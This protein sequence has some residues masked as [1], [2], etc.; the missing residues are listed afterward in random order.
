[1]IIHGT[2]CG[3]PIRELLFDTPDRFAI[4]VEVQNDQIEEGKKAYRE[5]FVRLVDECP[6]LAYWWMGQDVPTARRCSPDPIT[7]VRRNYSVPTQAEFETVLDLLPLGH[8]GIL[9]LPRS[10]MSIDHFPGVGDAP[11]DADPDPLAP[12]LSITVFDRF[13]AE[14]TDLK[15]ETLSWSVGAEREAME[16]PGGWDIERYV[17]VL[18][19]KNQ[20]KVR[21]LLESRVNSHKD[22]VNKLKDRYSRCAVVF[23]KV[24]ASNLKSIQKEL[25]DFDFHA[26]YNK[27]VTIYISKGIANTE[28]F[29]NKAKN[30][31]LL[32]G[33]S[34]TDHWNCLSEALKRW[35]TVLAYLQDLKNH[36]AIRGES[37]YIPVCDPLEAEANSGFLRDQEIIDLGYTVYISEA[38]RYRMLNNSLS[39][40]T[41]RF[42]CVMDAMSALD[43]RKRFVKNYLNRLKIREDD[44]AGQ[45]D[46]TNE[47]NKIVKDES[48]SNRRAMNAVK[49]KQNN[50][51]DSYKKSTGKFPAGSCRWHP[52]ATTHNTES[53][54]AKGEASGNSNN[55][56][57]SKR[58]FKPC[59][60]CKEHHPHLADGHPREKC[61]SDENSP[62]FKGV[63][64]AKIA[65][66]DDERKGNKKSKKRKAQGQL[67]RDDF[68]TSSGYDFYTSNQSQMN[69]F[70]KR[71]SVN[72]DENSGNDE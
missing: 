5:S 68:K 11:P 45:E 59:S 3:K 46:I 34:I 9:G 37:T 21:S 35:A 54:R 10:N 48:N 2:E 50:Q 67:T 20:N 16:L 57:K 19:H 14:M 33:Q 61:W 41:D 22:A 66:G 31:F 8:D 39:R 53:C 12:I 72:E 44:Q 25:N 69:D 32:A 6:W 71:V 47:L 58:D 23:D 15:T 62:E 27:L 70:L 43:L 65:V 51:R 55:S 30:V 49:Q 29:E 52:T 26:A 42:K 18:T 56:V 60:Y 17:D 13:A 64:N 40:W 38:T 24:G 1:M 4:I 7:K 28:E 63:R 36:I